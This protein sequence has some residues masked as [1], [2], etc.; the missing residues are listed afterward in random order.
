MIKGRV[1]SCTNSKDKPSGYI[2]LYHDSIAIDS[3]WTYH[4]ALFGDIYWTNGKFN[5]KG[6]QNGIYQIRY[7]TYFDT[8]DFPTFE[9]SDANLKCIEICFI[10]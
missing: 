1:I 10:F 7:E 6:L 2:Y 8:Q 4:Q 5:F 9:I 3:V